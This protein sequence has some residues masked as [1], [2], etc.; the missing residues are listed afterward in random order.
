MFRAVPQG[1]TYP[2]RDHVLC[3]GGVWSVVLQLAGE[4]YQAFFESEFAAHEALNASRAMPPDTPAMPATM[5]MLAAPVALLPGAT[6]LPGGTPA[7]L[8]QTA[9]PE[10]PGV[11][12]PASFG[13]LVMQ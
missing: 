3:E 1:I 2:P 11:L 6:G 7:Q 13:S 10:P 5:Q 4:T 12:M 9:D 8:Q